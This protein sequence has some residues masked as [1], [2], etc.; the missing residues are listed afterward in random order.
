MKSNSSTTSAFHGRLGIYEVLTTS[1]EIQKMIVSGSTS[2]LLQNQAV[3]EGMVTMQT[4]G[5]IKSLRGQ[6]TIEEVM[7]VTSER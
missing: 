4:D 6:T 1:P 3:K 5:L 2:E 7:R